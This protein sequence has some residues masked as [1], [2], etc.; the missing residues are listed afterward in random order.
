[1]RAEV[2]ALKMAFKRSDGPKGAISISNFVAAQE[3]P[4]VPEFTQGVGR[5]RTGCNRRWDNPRSDHVGAS[6]TLHTGRIREPGRSGRYRFG[7]QS[8][9]YRRQSERL[10]R[11]R[12]LYCRKMGGATKDIAPRVTRVGLI[13]GGPEVSTIGERFYSMFET[14]AR[15]SSVEPV[16]IRI[17]SAT[18][19]DP[20]IGAFAMQ[21]NMGL[22]AAAEVAAVTYRASIIDL[23]ARR[24]IPAVYPF[25][26]FATDGGLR[27]MASPWSTSIAAP[28]FTSIEYWWH[29]PGR[30]ASTSAG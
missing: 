11:F 25:R 6:H 2:S 18:D 16:A 15:A 8:R 21:P 5:S 24:N 14:A 7:A 1:M 29:Q 30:A 13:F 10:H 26:F 22:V 23:V 17:R 19:V 28:H 3:T 20:G 4:S 27:P 12:I 9:K